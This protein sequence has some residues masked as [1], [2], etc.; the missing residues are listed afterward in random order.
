MAGKKKG[1]IKSGKR[2]MRRVVEGE[3]AAPKKAQ[4]AAAKDEDEDKPRVSERIQEKD[5]GFGV[6]KV[7]VGVIVVLILAAGVFSRMFGNQDA[8]R[9][10]K[11]QGDICESTP[12]CKSGLICYAY[13]G[14]KHRCLADCRGDE[15]CEPGFTCVSMVERAGRK[16]TRLRAICVEDAKVLPA[17]R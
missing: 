4:A 8:V 9:G 17:D 1:K 16:S 7:V 11:T 2:V 5:S 3:E 12:D 14:G 15:R 6:I 10:D 13:G